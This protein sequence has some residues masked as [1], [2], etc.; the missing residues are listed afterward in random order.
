MKKVFAI[1]GV[2]VCSPVFA[3]D[4]VIISD[5]R[6]MTIIY[7][8]TKEVT[9]SAD[10]DA[11]RKRYLLQLK[12]EIS[13]ERARDTQRYVTDSLARE[14]LVDQ[15]IADIETRQRDMQNRGMA[16]TDEDILAMAI[17]PAENVTNETQTV[18]VGA[19]E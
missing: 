8:D 11:A 16:I 15:E 14:A 1:V 10:D 19:N 17:V 6:T 7:S 12:K 4:E 2:L 13:D 3:S 5:P 9:F 18:S